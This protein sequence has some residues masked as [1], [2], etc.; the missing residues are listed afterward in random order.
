[1]FMPP[2]IAVSS[3][4]PSAPRRPVIQYFSWSG[5][6][7][8]RIDS[9]LRSIAPAGSRSRRSAFC[10]H[11]ASSTARVGEVAGATVTP[12]SRP[13]PRPFGQ[14]RGD[15]TPGLVVG[16]DEGLH[17]DELGVLGIGEAARKGLPAVDEQPDP[18]AGAGGRERGLVEGGHGAR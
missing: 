13:C 3:S 5:G 2:R 11:S 6:F 8:R 12:A 9:A 16:E 1:M 14:Q 17:Q 15:A 10:A 7:A 18:V 4:P